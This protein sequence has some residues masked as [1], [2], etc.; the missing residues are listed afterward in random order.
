V[1][2]QSFNSDSVSGMQLDFAVEKSFYPLGLASA[3]VTFRAFSAHNLSAAGD[4]EAAFRAFMC[5]Q[6]WHLVFPLSLLWLSL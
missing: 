3:Q 6:L 1:G 2:N 5:F 4:M